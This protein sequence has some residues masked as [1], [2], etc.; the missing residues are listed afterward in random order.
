MPN[1]THPKVSITQLYLALMRVAR[2]DDKL[3]K[4]LT[5]LSSQDMDKDGPCQ[6]NKIYWPATATASILWDEKEEHLF[7]MN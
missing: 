7:K 2:N 1:I 5:E 4:S 6:S 3:Q